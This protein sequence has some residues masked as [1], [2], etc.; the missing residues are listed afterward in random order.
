M[1]RFAFLFAILV[2][3]SAVRIHAAEKEATKSDTA[4]S[5]TAKSDTAKP[6]KVLY[7]TGGGYHDYE[8][9]TPLLTGGMKKHANVEFDD[10]WGLDALRDKKLGEGY[11]AIVYNICYGQDNDLPLIENAIRVTREGKPTVLVHCSMHC[12]QA[13][14]AW[15]ECCGM[16]TRVHDPYRAFGTEKVKA[17]H[18]AIKQFPDD[19]KTPGDEL[20]QTINLPETSTSL[21]QSSRLDAKGKKSTVCWVHKHGKANV[22]ATTLGH[23]MKTCE[24]D[25]Y[26]S[27]LAHGLLWTC[28]KLDE[29][30][31]PAAGY[32]AAK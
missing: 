32:A 2:V 5:D 26:H 17:D 12:F 27:L 19:W 3:L 25:A 1:K 7:I 29:N 16:R 10:K 15:T 20:Y 4:K 23:D 24:Q 22:F 13:S 6:L 21:L 14:D 9:L 8:K 31:K 28:G 18:P 30:G 11:D